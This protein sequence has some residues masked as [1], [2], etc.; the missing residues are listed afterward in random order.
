MTV[1]DVSPPFRIEFSP[2][3]YGLKAH[4]KGINGTLETTLAYW[5]K[6]AMEVRRLQPAG[7]LVLDDM[8]GDPPPPEQLLQFVHAMRGEGMENV[9]VAYVEKHLEQIPQVELASIL[10]NELGF[11]GHV[12]DNERSATIWLRYGE[13]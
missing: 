11:N 5:R 1:Q 13:Q 3:D 8:E 7:L 12:F 10:A 4:V 2:A 9:R 6:I